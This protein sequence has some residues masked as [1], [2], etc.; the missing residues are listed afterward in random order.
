MSELQELLQLTRENNEMLKRIC[1]H[2]DATRSANTQLNEDIK[3]FIINVIANGM[4][5][6]RM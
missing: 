6:N 4:Y 3:N 2:I 1:R 5:A